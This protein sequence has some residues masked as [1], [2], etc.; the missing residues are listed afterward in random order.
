MINV[1]RIKERIFILTDDV[2]CSEKCQSEIIDKNKTEILFRLNWEPY[3]SGIKRE[4]RQ[5]ADLLYINDG[6]IDEAY[7]DMKQV[8]QFFEDNRLKEKPEFET[9]RLVKLDEEGKIRELKKY[10]ETLGILKNFGLI[11]EKENV[12]LDIDKATTYIIYNEDVFNYVSIL[13][14]EDIMNLATQWINLTK[15]QQELIREF[16]LKPSRESKLNFIRE[17]LMTDIENFYPFFP[18]WYKVNLYVFGNSNEKIENQRKDYIEW[19]SYKTLNYKELEKDKENEEL[20]KKEIYAKIPLGVTM[21]GDQI[22]NIL[23]EIFKQYKLNPTC[24]SSKLYNISDYF[25]MKKVRGGYKFIT[26]KII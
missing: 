22:K 10:K 7:R 17:E 26:R 3:L 13:F 21:S 25:E 6:P 2:L 20:V 15:N 4:L 16:Y 19:N 18:D 9:Y 24:H 5:Y 11:D 12:N 8:I 14:G 23:D 1:I